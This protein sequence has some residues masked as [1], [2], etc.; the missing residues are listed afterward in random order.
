VE[1]VS[2]AT[3]RKIMKPALQTQSACGGFVN[4]RRRLRQRG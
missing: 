4:E 1:G 2:P 3:P